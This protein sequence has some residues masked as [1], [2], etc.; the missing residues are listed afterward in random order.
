MST[1]FNPVG[2]HSSSVYWVRRALILVPLIALIV[3]VILGLRALLPGGDDATSTTPTTAPTSGQGETTT[4][5]AQPSTPAPTAAAAT[6][7]AAASPTI[8]SCTAQQI[9]IVATTDKDSYPRD[10]KAKAK[11]GMT[12]TNTSD[13]PCTMDF[14][15]G[16]L[17]LRV[18]SGSDRI[19]S[20][21][22]CQTEANS[23]MRTIQP[24]EAGR[25]VSTVE[26]A[27]Q[28]SAPGCRSVD[29]EV[30]LGNYRLIARAGDLQSQPKAFIIT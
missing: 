13:T 15:N 27:L 19:W 21:D 23:D 3:A 12:I 10:A 14:G 29:T 16:P 4:P 5:N 2:P 22:D 1:L 24:G 11:L 20:S 17:E 26:W 9:K 30:G 28:R 25:M 6:A 7:S 18:T 8:A